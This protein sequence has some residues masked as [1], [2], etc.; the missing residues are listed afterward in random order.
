MEEMQ[1][2]QTTVQADDGRNKFRALTQLE[3]GL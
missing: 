3:G 2:L 1:A